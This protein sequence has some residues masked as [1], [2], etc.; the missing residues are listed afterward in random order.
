MII[1]SNNPLSELIRLK[2]NPISKQA[3]G[4]KNFIQEEENYET[5][6]IKVYTFVL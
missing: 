3:F 2:K 4:S 6:Y 5:D 1:F